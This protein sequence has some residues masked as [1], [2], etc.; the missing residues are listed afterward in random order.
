MTTVLSFLSAACVVAFFAVL[1]GFVAKLG[2]VLSAVASQLH[3][4]RDAAARM[5]D[6]CATIGPA[7]DGMNQNLYTVAAE[8][9][10]IGDAAEAL[11]EST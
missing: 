6:D 3:S 5:R 11:I 1:C 7:V 4:V 8:L 10:A 2:S 9:S